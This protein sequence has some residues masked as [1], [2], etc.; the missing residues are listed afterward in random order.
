MA[1]VAQ[2]PTSE[3]CGSR[4]VGYVPG[5]SGWSTEYR[6]YV[7]SAGSG[8]SRAISRQYSRHAVEDALE[9]LIRE[10]VAPTHPDLPGG[11]TF[12]VV[13]AP[14]HLNGLDMGFVAR[15]NGYYVD[16]E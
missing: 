2:R 10:G 16:Y 3:R 4:A 8:R 9:G 1:L 11:H 6:R 12:A 13:G 15:L 14:A 7:R 5:R